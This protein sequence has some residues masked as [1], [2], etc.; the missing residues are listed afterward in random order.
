MAQ[1]GPPPGEE[2]FWRKKQI[3]VEKTAK[4]G[5]KGLRVGMTIYIEPQPRDLHRSH[6]QAF[7]AV[8]TGICRHL[9]AFAVI[10]SDLQAFT[11]RHLHRFTCIY[12]SLKD[13][14]VVHLHRFTSFKPY[15]QT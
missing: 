14:V 2:K 15:P 1:N 10:Y 6:L 5:R 7:T 9:Q 4:F 8:F 12:T 11:M 3:W 13:K